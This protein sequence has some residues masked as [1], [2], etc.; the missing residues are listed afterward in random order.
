M[1][2][3]NSS[4]ER[5]LHLEI[6]LLLPG[7]EDGRD[8]CV[9][10]LQESLLPVAGIRLAHVERADGAAV[11]CLHYDP[12]L[13]SL[14]RV[15]RLAREAGAAIAERYRHESLHVIG[16]DCADCA[17]SLEH[18]LRRAPGMINTAVSYAAEKIRVEYDAEAISHEDV[19]RRIRG[20]GYDVVQKRREAWWDL[21][22]DLILS[23]LAGTLLTVG[24]VGETYLGLPHAAAVAAYALAYLS[25]G[26]DIARH[27]VV[28]ALNLRFDVDVLMILAAIGAAALGDWP[29]G[30]FL[31]FLFSLGHALEKSALDKARNA[32]EALGQLTPKTA[33]VRRLG[34]EQESPVEELLRGDVVIVRPGERLPAD[35]RL[36]RGSTTIDQGPVTGESMPVQKEVG[37]EVFAGTVNGSGA[38]EVEVTKLSADSTLARVFQLIEEAQTQKSP[39]ERTVERLQGWFVPA[40]LGAVVLTAVLPPALGLLSLR[41]SLIRA[42]SLLVAASPCAL[43]LATPSAVLA[44]I[45]QGARN[46][47][48]IKG[49]VHLENLG[50]VRAVAF[51]K[52]GTLTR[53]S[54]QV[55]T[56]IP[57]GDAT[58]QQ[59][60][61]VAAS[62]ESRSAHPLAVAVVRH[63]S[64]LGLRFEAPDRLSDASGLGVQGE[65]R[66]EI[67]RVG[68]ERYFAVDEADLPAEMQ[69]VLLRLAAEGKTTMIVQLSGIYLGV[70]GLADQPRPEARQSLASLKSAGM[71]PIVMLTGDHRAVAEAVAA[72]V[73]VTQVEAGLMPDDKVRTVM[74][75]RQRYAHVAMVGDGVNDAPALAAATVGIAMGGAGTD[76]ALETADVALM[77]DDLLALPYAFA[78]GRL[79][80]QIV[81]QNLTIALGVIGVLV[82]AAVTG[83]TGVGPAIVVHESSTLLV[84]L[85]ALRL[86]GFR[87][88]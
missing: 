44:G 66:G 24:F 36:I 3:R 47:V 38:I 5:T 32:I 46:G 43:A 6:P 77:A 17:V 58:S 37:D 33:H 13:L 55:T 7:V 26:Y 12:D 25:A 67:A 48:L 1:D 64:D 65:I 16:M 80:R 15:E 87:K 62:L 69:S 14:D 72:E 28:A 74:S 86:L 84:V 51:D 71:G 11:L 52:T 34:V 88:T 60:L 30:A 54:P 41:Q 35:G 20:L 49:G 23:L 4:A 76:V 81:N 40:V 22:A 56:A 85:N 57:L 59:L 70:I 45:A 82:L 18:I 27:A 10:R 8:Q 53:G 9:E 73:G 31:L 78:L 68:G 83:L 75:L 2:E 19:L 50:R 39:T 42:I 29:E 21:H 61:R 79:T 63:V